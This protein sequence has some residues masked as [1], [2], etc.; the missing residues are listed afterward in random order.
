MH[1]LIADASIDSLR[2]RPLSVP[3]LEPFVIATGRVDTTR[4]VEV[5][6]TVAHRGATAIGLG[7]AAC[8]PP[9]T[10]EDQGDV[11]RALERP[12]RIEDIPSLGEVARAGVETAVLD[13]MARIARVPLRVLLG[14]DLGTRTARLETD[15]TVAIAPPAK[16]GELARAWAAKGF[17]SIKV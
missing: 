6:V 15:I 1:G 5:E 2:A 14:G 10:S 11:L 17:R 12:L 16:M 8:L 3:L 4:A 7:E 13:A 9:V